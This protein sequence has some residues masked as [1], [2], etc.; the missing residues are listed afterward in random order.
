MGGEERERERGTIVPFEWAQSLE[1]S[2]RTKKPPPKLLPLTE[3]ALAKRHRLHQRYGGQ[4]HPV[5]D[6]SNRPDPWRRRPREGV[7]L[8]RPAPLVDVDAR[9]FQAQIRGVGPA[10]RAEHYEGRALDAAGGAVRVGVVDVDER[11]G[12]LV[13]AGRGVFGRLDEPVFFFRFPFPSVFCSLPSWSFCR[14]RKTRSRT[15]E[16]RTKEPK[17]KKA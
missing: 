16:G 12:P 4:R 2:K 6:V 8:D 1:T 7:H 13:A 10:A 5:R 11:A 9:L 14:L 17:E 15:R 3:R